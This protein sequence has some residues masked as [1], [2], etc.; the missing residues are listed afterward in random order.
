M[1]LEPRRAS[2]FGPSGTKHSGAWGEIGGVDMRNGNVVIDA[3]GKTVALL[4]LAYADALLLP[5]AIEQLRAE[6]A[7]G[8]R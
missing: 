7:A 3:R 1:A 4:P 5:G 8:A 2:L 6:A